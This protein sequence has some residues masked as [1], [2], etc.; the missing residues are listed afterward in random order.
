MDVTTPVGAAGVNA[1]R[2]VVDN[3]AELTPTMFLAITLYVYNTPV[4]HEV[5][6]Y[7]VDVTFCAN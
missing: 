1:H 3:E 7:E 4:V 6:I 5:A 2:T